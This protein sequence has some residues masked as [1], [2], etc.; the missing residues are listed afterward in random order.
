MSRSRLRPLLA[1]LLAASAAV[2]GSA[3][4]ATAGAAI[5][6]GG[7]RPGTL[8]LTTDATFTY[9]IG[10][11][12]ALGAQLHA[13]GQLTI[14]NRSAASGSFDFGAALG[15][16][17][18]PMALQYGVG[19]GQTNDAQRLHT[20]ATVGTTFHL[21]RQRRAGLGV[22]LFGGWTQ[23]WSQARLVRP[24]LGI[25]RKLDDSYGVWTSGAMLKFDYR[26][27]RHLGATVQAAVPCWG[28]QPSYVATIFHVGAGLT[29]YLK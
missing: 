9:G 3:A 2:S 5:A 18:E 15:F 8:H 13:V 12:S 6:A 27:S 14:W 26:F 28:A 25:D 22:H 23:M 16:Q 7:E 1:A 24:D 11:Y 19:K 29:A 4:A 17:D 20:W 21:G 10:G